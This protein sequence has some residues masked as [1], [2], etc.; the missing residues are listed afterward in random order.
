MKQFLLSIYQPDG[1]KPPPRTLAAIM[2]KVD[3][4][5]RELESTG[6][7]VFSGGLQP[8]GT[9]RVVRGQ[10]GRKATTRG[11][12][13]GGSQHLGGF[14]IVRA[15]DFDAALDW[16]RKLARATTL[17]VEVREIQ[18][19][20]TKGSPSRAALGNGRNGGHPSKIRDLPGRVPD[21]RPMR[22]PRRPEAARFEQ[23]R[24]TGAKRRLG[25]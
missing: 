7:A 25:A 4:L 20:P 14:K 13:L 18:D 8:P 19:R 17:P 5:T 9:A 24:R 16:G 10:D 21:K 1:P 15:P 23:G 6:A 11:P 12:F 3:E 2:R 22:M